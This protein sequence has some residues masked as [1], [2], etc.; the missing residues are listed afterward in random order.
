[1]LQHA[2]GDVFAVGGS[3]TVQAVPSCAA[4]CLC[5]AV[6]VG[7]S[8]QDSVF[9]SHNRHTNI[10]MNAHNHAP[11]HTRAQPFVSYWKNHMFYK[12]PREGGGETYDRL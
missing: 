7:L 9:I 10:H 11:I 2:V 1:M 4:M 6:E 8:W 3:F 12:N 5:T